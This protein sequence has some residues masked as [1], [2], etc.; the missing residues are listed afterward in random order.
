MKLNLILFAFAI[1]IYGVQPNA[2][3]G[4]AEISPESAQALLVALN[5]LLKESQN[6]E[7][8][9]K[10]VV[11][12][13]QTIKDVLSVQTSERSLITDLKHLVALF[14]DGLGSVI[15]LLLPPGQDI[16]DVIAE[17]LKKVVRW[18]VHDNEPLLGLLDKLILAGENIARVAIESALDV[19]LGEPVELAK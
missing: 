4:S 10:K 5:K 17:A 19:L 8:V 3:P 6:P 7:H 16:F 13:T 9:Q 12:K 2:V 11:E 1:C 18:F 15:N 14:V